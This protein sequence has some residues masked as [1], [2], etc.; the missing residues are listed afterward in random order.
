[1]YQCTHVPMY[2]CTVPV[3]T[4][5][6][7]DEYVNG[8]R[9]VTLDIHIKK[10]FRVFSAIRPDDRFFSMRALHAHAY[11]FYISIIP[12]SFSNFT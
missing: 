10:R 3:S 12:V 6:T 8:A 5:H 9:S 4:L 11:D 2:P 1:M 7:P